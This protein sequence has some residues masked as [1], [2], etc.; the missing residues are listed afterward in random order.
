MPEQH[1][2]DED[3]LADAIPIDSLEDD[4]EVIELTDDDVE[5]APARPTASPAEAPVIE[6]DLAESEDDSPAE[7]RTFGKAK[8]EKAAWKR[9]P[10][11]DGSGATHVRTFVAKLRMDAIEHLEDQV[12]AWLDEHPE[13]EVKFVT[14]NVGILTG[15][16]KE[17]ALFMSV[18]V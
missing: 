6:I 11:A 1:K 10:N 17:D 16:T 14:S 4:D 9:Q 12:N 7:I 2:S 8:S 3:L 15:K 13:I 18:W 5:A